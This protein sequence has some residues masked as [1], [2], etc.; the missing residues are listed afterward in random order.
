MPV[1][2]SIPRSVLK[3]IGCVPPNQENM[4]FIE[5][6]T[7]TETE[8]EGENRLRGGGSKVKGGKARERKR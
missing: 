2:N 3:K 5:R 6:E 1:N 4:V 7:E 8:T